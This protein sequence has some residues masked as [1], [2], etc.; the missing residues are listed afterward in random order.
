MRKVMI[1]HNV[2]PLPA[3]S[4]RG[5]SK[6]DN[7]SVR[8]SQSWAGKVP[9]LEELFVQGATTVVVTSVVRATI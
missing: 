4:S 2:P 5:S 7:T 3:K 6:V 1:E 9:S 8:A